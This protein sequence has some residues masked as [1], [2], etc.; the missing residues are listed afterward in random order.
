VAIQFEI[1]VS[2][3]TL[4]IVSRID[5]FRGDWSASPGVSPD[6]LDRLR[7]AARIQSIGASC[8]LSGIHISDH[9]VAGVL[10]GE[11]VPMPDTRTIAGYDDAIKFD[12]E[13]PG[14][15]D[16]GMLQRLNAAV[17]AVGK[18][19]SSSTPGEECCWRRQPSHCET[20]DA[21]GQATGRVIPIL[22]PRLIEE[23]LEELLTWF[24]LEMREGQRHPLP[25]IATFVLGLLAICPFES[26][27]GRTIRALTSHLL[28]RAGYS[29]APYASLESQMEDVRQD[30]YSAFDQSQS[31]IWTGAAD[32]SPWL[33]YFMELLDR[34][35]ARVEAKVNLERE[36]SELSPL[37]QSIMETVREHGTVDAGLL[38]KATG[39]NRN[40]LK[41]NVRRL[42]AQGV[43][44]KTGERRTTRYRLASQHPARNALGVDPVS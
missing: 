8:R 33:D 35:R 15:L 20:F 29:Y 5:R 44:E 17:L 13:Q 36:A 39:A 11:S 22:P 31:G 32:F 7:E 1:P 2:Q 37:Q 38:L 18:E 27:N 43:L 4:S 21:N 25:V 28:L 41:D 34:H 9:E 42:V 14:L 23:T 10:R 3:A 12:L 16:M 6:R 30:Y 26:G 40:T 24:E 19:G